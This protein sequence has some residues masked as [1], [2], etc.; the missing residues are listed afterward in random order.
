[1]SGY[2]INSI[3]ESVDSWSTES[4]MLLSNEMAV[5]GNESVSD[6]YIIHFDNPEEMYNPAKRNK[7]FYEIVI[8]HIIAFVLGVLGN[9]VAVAVMIGDCC[10]GRS[11]TNL[12][13]VR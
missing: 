6:S 11:A 10:S 9:T 5:E 2:G 3:M 8:T 1:M 12:F 13:L 7:L 4:T